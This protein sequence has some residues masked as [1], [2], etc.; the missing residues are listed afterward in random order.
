LRRSRLVVR[1]LQG[2]TTMSEPIPPIDP[3]I[4]TPRR[5]SWFD[6]WLL[7]AVIVVIILGGVA[8]IVAPRLGL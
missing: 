3:L 2:P 7:T 1:A 5:P 4:T 8:L 6:E